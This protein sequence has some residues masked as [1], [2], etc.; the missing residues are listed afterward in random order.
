VTWV[1]VVLAASAPS[2]QSA[3]AAITKNGVQAK[4]DTRRKTIFG[5]NDLMGHIAILDESP[6]RA[7]TNFRHADPA[8]NSL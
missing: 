7:V 1:S 2:D 6:G 8:I 3:T 5:D 4:R